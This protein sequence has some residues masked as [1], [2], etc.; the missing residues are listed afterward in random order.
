VSDL[1][2]PTFSN[3]NAFKI[4]QLRGI[5]HT[6]PYFHD[7]SAKTVEDV[8]VHYDKFFDLTTGGAIRLTPQDQKDMVAFMKLLDCCVGGPFRGDGR[9]RTCDVRNDNGA[10]LGSRCRRMRHRAL[11][12]RHSAPPDGRLALVTATCSN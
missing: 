10:A 8:M 4:P 11:A 3:V 9:A 2:D 6:A 7:N 1:E 5:R 12:A